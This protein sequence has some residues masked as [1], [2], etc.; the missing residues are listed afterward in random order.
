MLATNLGLEE[1]PTGEKAW[2]DTVPVSDVFG[3]LRA[4]LV[5]PQPP[6]RQNAPSIQEVVSALD[7]LLL[8]AEEQAEGGMPLHTMAPTHEEAVNDD[9][10]LQQCVDMRDDSV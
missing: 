3:Q 7:A 5:N 10:Q 2:S 1:H 9:N 4:Q 6:T 8:P